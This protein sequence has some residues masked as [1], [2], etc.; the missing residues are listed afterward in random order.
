M[1]EKQEK[2]HLR[3]MLT[4]YTPGSVLDLLATIYRDSAEDARYAGDLVQYEQC[5]MVERALVVV[6]HGVDAVC[7]R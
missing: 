6:A 4:A 1:S 7:P 2:K 3:R 5:R